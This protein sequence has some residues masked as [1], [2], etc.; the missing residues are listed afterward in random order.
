MVSRFMWFIIIH[1]CV[2]EKIVCASGLFRN[3][4][5]TYDYMIL[6]IRLYYTKANVKKY[7]Q[8]FGYHSFSFFIHNLFILLPIYYESRWCVFYVSITPQWH[9]MNN[10]ILLN[11]INEFIQIL[12]ERMNEGSVYSA[13]IIIVQSCIERNN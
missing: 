13:R 10:S 9:V 7:L 1:I 4:I 12:T 6:F 8:N 5:F 3:I 11:L 2:T